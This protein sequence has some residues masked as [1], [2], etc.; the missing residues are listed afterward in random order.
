M[1]KYLFNLNGPIKMINQ[2]KSDF[3]GNNL[4]WAN[5]S[6]LEENDKGSEILASCTYSSHFDVFIAKKRETRLSR[7]IKYIFPQH[8]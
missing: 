7:C 6:N 5:Q 4:I 3:I 1:Y 2:S 8:Q